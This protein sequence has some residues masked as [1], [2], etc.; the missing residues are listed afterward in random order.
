MSNAQIYTVAAAMVMAAL[1]M[2]LLLPRGNQP[3]R[4]LGGLLSLISLALFGTLA[5]PLGSWGADVVFAVLAAVTLASAAAAVT[6]RSPHYCAIW[7]ALSLLGTAAL[8][9]VQGAQFLGVATIVVY[10]GA[11]LVTFLFVLMLAQPAGQAYYDRVSWDGLLSASAGAVLV[12]VLTV[13]VTQVLNPYVDPELA[14]AIRSFQPSPAAPA[15]DPSTG[16]STAA[17][18]P[19]SA[20]HLRRATLVRMSDQTYLAR[21][22][23]T[24]AAPSLSTEQRDKLADHLLIRV[25]RLVADKVARR[26]LT[27]QISGGAALPAP[28]GLAA[29]STADPPPH[30]TR[31]GNILSSRHVARLGADLFSRHLVSIEVAGTLLLVALVGAIA[32][33]CHDRPAGELRNVSASSRTEKG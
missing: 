31:E 22:E 23:L 21:L 32:I 13:T 2:W 18:A 12:A 4:W 1:G 14:A 16:E 3:G 17:T 25:S 28:A 33:V 26:D 24:P 6:F 5:M 7:F 10:A 20:D 30:K 9:M 19:I 8:F 15:G 11:I 27:L 29:A